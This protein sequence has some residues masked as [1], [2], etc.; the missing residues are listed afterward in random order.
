[1]ARNVLLFLLLAW[2]SCEI[3]DPQSAGS[4]WVNRGG[5]GVTPQSLGSFYRAWLSDKD[6]AVDATVPAHSGLAPRTH[7]PF[8]AQMRGFE[9]Q[10]SYKDGPV[11]AVTLYSLISL[12]CKAE[13]SA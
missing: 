10:G 9:H 7:V 13:K 11:Q 2:G 3:R 1:V 6:D 12:A 4:V 8:F 5:V